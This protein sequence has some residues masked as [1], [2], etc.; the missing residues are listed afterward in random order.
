M[1]LK[2]SEKYRL[3]YHE[4]HTLHYLS[5]GFPPKE[6]QQ[7]LQNHFEAWKV[8]TVMESCTALLGDALLHT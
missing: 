4:V 2:I 1:I 3:N 8:N 7:Q 5:Q 6:S